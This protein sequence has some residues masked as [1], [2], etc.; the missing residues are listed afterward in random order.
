[1]ITPDFS[2]L[3]DL[4]KIIPQL[5]NREWYR[6]RERSLEMRTRSGA[7]V[8]RLTESALTPND[9]GATAPRMEPESL[10]EVGELMEKMSEVV[11]GGKLND[12][13]EDYESEDEEADEDALLNIVA[14]AF[15]R[16]LGTMD[17]AS[18]PRYNF[19]K[20]RAVIHIRN[21]VFCGIA[22]VSSSITFTETSRF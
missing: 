21:M 7:A 16:R 14:A 15:E 10:Q 5:E 12:T 17:G 6:E 11:P 20:I 4:R 19:G 1:M 3:R 8:N 13:T 18:E 22:L 9:D 2:H